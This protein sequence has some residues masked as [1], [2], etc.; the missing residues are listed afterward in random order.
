MKGLAHLY[1]GNGK[2]KTTAAVGLAVRAAGQKMHVIFAQ[3]FKTMPT[4]EITELEKLG[5][6]VLRAELPAGFTWSMTEE[7]LAVIRTEHDQLLKKAFSLVPADERTLLVLD[8]AV[9]AFA[10]GYLDKNAALACFCS[11]PEKTELVLTGHCA[12]D[13][14]VSICDYI[15]EMKACRHPYENGITARKGIEF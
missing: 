15:T 7:E 11:R 1:Y 6:T 12:P 8:E 3:F 10:H 9:D 14:I 4:G 2:G 5:I 13:E